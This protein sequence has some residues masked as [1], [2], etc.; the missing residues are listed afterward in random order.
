[1]TEGDDD[2][3]DFLLE[4]FDRPNEVLYFTNRFELGKESVYP[5]F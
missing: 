4:D 5:K 3:D 1:M 2:E